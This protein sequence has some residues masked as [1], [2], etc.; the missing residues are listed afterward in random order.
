M[1]CDKN[2][3]RN[4]NCEN[5]SAAFQT[6]SSRRCFVRK[7]FHIP[8]KTLNLNEVPLFQYIYKC[9]RPDNISGLREF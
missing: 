7:N 6:G 3:E 5:T 1:R 9:F 8:R 4:Q 2:L